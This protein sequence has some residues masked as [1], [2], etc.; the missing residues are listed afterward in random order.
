MGVKKVSGKVELNVKSHF[1]GI[2]PAVPWG[3]L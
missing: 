3:G 2:G 1:L